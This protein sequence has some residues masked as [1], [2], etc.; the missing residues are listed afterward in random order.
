MTAHISRLAPRN[1]TH[2]VRNYAG[3]LS[4]N[5]PRLRETPPNAHLPWDKRLRAPLEDTAFRSGRNL[6]SWYTCNRSLLPGT[7]KTSVPSFPPANEDVGV[8]RNFEAWEAALRGT[9]RIGLA[10]EGTFLAPP[11]V[12]CWRAP[13]D[14]RFSSFT[15]LLAT[16]VLL[17]LSS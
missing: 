17:L 1:Q 15:S 14:P 10:V 8:D 6:E 13:S 5:Y 3:A 9:V 12:C 11:P 7:A 16:V 4:V 2:S